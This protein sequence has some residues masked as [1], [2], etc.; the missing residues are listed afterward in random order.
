VGWMVKMSLPS[1]GNLKGT[2]L[3]PHKLARGAATKVS[4][5]RCVVALFPFKLTAE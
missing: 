1:W 3:R 5:R 2:G 4:S